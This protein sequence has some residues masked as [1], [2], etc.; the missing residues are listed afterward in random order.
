MFILRKI[1][2]AKIGEEEGR[3]KAGDSKTSE[4]D[5]NITTI[6]YSIRTTS[7]FPIVN[8]YLHPQE[9]VPVQSISLYN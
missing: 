7:S 6:S 2:K 3:K 9:V 8:N 1:K 4:T 5:L